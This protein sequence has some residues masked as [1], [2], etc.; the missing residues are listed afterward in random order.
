MGYP[1][2]GTADATSDVITYSYT[3]TNTGNAAISGVVVTDDNGTPGN[4]ADDLTL[5]LS[6][7]DTDSD[8]ALDVNETWTYSATKAV[9]QA[10]LDD[11][12]D[13][14]LLELPLDEHSAIRDD[15]QASQVVPAL[16]PAR[17]SEQ[18]GSGMNQHENSTRCTG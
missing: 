5:T 1:A 9:T 3:V 11:G 12:S 10:M 8:G 4:T 18:L 7:G 15:A 17:E 2:G 6:S 13:I 14:H 16:W